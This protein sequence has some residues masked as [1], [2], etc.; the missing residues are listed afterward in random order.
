HR[1]PDDAGVWVEAHAGLAFGHRR[2]AVLDLS[3]AGRQP[4]VSPSGRFVIVFN[5]EIYNYGSLRQALDV[6]G[7]PVS[8]Q[9][10]SDTETL[11]ACFEAWGIEA[12]LKRCVGMFAFALWDRAS[13]SL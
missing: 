11:L 6:Q 1:G 8:W 10:H 4:M 7:Y 13:H 3:P 2:L 9:G 12:T 5:G